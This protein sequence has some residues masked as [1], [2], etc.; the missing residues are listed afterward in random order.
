LYFAGFDH[1]TWTNTKG[2]QRGNSVVIGIVGEEFI[3]LLPTCRVIAIVALL[4]D[5]CGY[6]WNGQH[7]NQKNEKNFKNFFGYHTRFPPRYFVSNL[8]TYINLL[9][10][11]L[12][13]P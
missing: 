8:G 13:G 2:I 1:R 6:G 11:L 3:P 4:I 9:V 5:G 10:E 12:L 7:G